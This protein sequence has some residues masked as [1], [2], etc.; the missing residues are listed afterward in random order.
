MQ[1]N[2]QDAMAIVRQFGKPDLFVTM[3]CNPKWV[4]IHENLQHGQ[5]AE[6]R[7]DLVARVFNMKLKE[8][9]QD[10][11]KKAYFRSSVGNGLRNRVSKKGF[12]ACSH[13]VDFG[14]IIKAFNNR[15]H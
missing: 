5:K 12:A 9:L 4:E 1:Q 15:S 10:I 3:T 13:V 7:P 2:F 6:N 8:I 11:T 14:T